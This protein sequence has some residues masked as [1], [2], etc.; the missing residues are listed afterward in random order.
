MQKAAM[1]PGRME[2]TKPKYMA[3]IGGKS[4]ILPRTETVV[5]T[6][7]YTKLCS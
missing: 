2:M 3:K 7:K 5:L 4:S 1:I 6:P